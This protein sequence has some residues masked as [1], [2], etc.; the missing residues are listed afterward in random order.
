MFFVSKYCSDTGIHM[1]LQNSLVGFS[2]KTDH[3]FGFLEFHCSLLYHGQTLANRAKPG[4]IAM[5][6]LG[7]ATSNTLKNGI[8]TQK[9]KFSKFHRCKNFMLKI[10]LK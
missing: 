2:Y 9:S 6:Q 3:P 7:V 8:Y 1:R 5:K 10:R 4:P